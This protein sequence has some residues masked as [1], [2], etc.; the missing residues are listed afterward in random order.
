MMDYSIKIHKILLLLFFNLLKLYVKSG[1]KRI[2]T[3]NR[4]FLKFKHRTMII[5][6]IWKKENTSP[7]HLLSLTASFLCQSESVT[8]KTQKRNTYVVLD[9]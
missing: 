9:I 5:T 6:K 2:R 7:S 4:F 3:F 1:S 8:N